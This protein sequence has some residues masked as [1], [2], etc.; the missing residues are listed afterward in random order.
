MFR[1]ARLSATAS[2]GERRCAHGVIGVSPMRRRRLIGMVWVILAIVVTVGIVSF[3][4]TEK[5]AS[6]LAITGL[7]CAAI[8]FIIIIFVVVLIAFGCVGAMFT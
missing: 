6:C 3:L 8:A 4:F 5:G 7:G 1:S 2:E